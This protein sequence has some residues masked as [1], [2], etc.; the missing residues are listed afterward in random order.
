MYDER[1]R[2]HENGRLGP[3]VVFGRNPTRLSEPP[4]ISGLCNVGPNMWSVS[5][6][7]LARPIVWTG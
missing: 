4:I 2:E 5:G 1:K 7:L 3:V 6:S